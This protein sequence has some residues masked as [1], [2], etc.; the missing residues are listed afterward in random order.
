MLL[1]ILEVKFNNLLKNIHINL[2]FQNWDNKNGI[3]GIYKILV[4]KKYYK[5]LGNKILIYIKM[6]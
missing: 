6:Y 3:H 4:I 5:K 2:I 1:V